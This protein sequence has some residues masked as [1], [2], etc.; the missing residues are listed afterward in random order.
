MCGRRAVG[1]SASL[2]ASTGG[3]VCQNYVPLSDVVPSAADRRRFERQSQS[4]Y[5][6]VYVD[7]RRVGRI[8]RSAGND[9]HSEQLLA[10]S[11]DWEDA[12]AAASRQGKPLDLVL[13]RTPCATT[14]Q[15]LVEELARDAKARGVQLRIIATGAYTGGNVPD[16]ATTT[17]WITRTTDN[18]ATIIVGVPGGGMRAGGTQLGDALDNINPPS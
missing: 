7:G 12:L 1:A 9:R 16:A 17:G 15:N 4:T 3:N 6:G 11:G 8:H 5:A 10:D 18:G 14:C 2:S 13:N